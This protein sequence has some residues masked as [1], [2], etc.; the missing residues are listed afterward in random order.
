MPAADLRGESAAERPNGLLHQCPLLGFGQST[1]MQMAHVETGRRDL[2]LA[3]GDLLGERG[4]T[5]R[6]RTIEQRRRAQ[7]A[8]IQHPHQAV[9]ADPVAV[10]ALG[11]VPVAPT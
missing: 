7:A 1:V 10:A 3:G 5:R 9:Y 2:P 6:D 8:L 11:I 4:V